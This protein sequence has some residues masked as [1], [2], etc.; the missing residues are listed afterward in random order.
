MVPMGRPF[1][2]DLQSRPRGEGPVGNF[3]AYRDSIKRVFSGS[4]RRTPRGSWV[5]S[6]TGVTAIRYQFEFDG[7]HEAV[8][9]PEVVFRFHN[10]STRAR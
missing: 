1:N 2:V 8:T 7:K 3:R 9:D 4:H 6:Q 5:K 10:K